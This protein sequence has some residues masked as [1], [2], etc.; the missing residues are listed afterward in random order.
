MLH[1]LFDALEDNFSIYEDFRVKH[2]DSQ[3]KIILT[4]PGVKKEDLNVSINA[5][6]LRVSGK[7]EFNQIQKSLYLNSKVEPRTAEASLVDGI[8]TVTLQ[9]SKKYQYRQLTLD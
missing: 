4:V 7:S 9:K 1:L 3:V 8:L 6:Y 2:E 5:D